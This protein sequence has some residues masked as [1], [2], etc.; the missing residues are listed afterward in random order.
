[1]TQKK[2]ASSKR[3]ARAAAAGRKTVHR[4]R[5][6]HKR[7]LLHPFSVMVLLCAGVLILGST[8]HGSADSYDVTASVN[9]PLP[10]APAVIITPLDQLHFSAQRITAE[11]TCPPASYV[12]LYR[13]GVFSGADVCSGNHFQILTYLSPGANSLEAKVY[14]VTNN[15]GPSSPPITLY[16]DVIENPPPP[17]SVPPVTLKIDRV[18]STGYRDGT[19]QTSVRPTLVGKAPP[20]SDVVVT[21]HSEVKT[22]LTQADGTGYWSC[23]L[24]EELPPGLHHV[25]VTATT[26]DGQ[27]LS[28]PSFQISALAALPDIIKQTL[29]P[30]LIQSEYSYQ[31]HHTGQTFTFSMGVGGGTAPFDVVVDWGDKQQTKLT[32]NDQNSF[33]V[34]HTYNESADY[35]IIVTMTDANGTSSSLQL[36]AVVRDT[37]TPAAVTKPDSG[38][39]ALLGDMKRFLWVIW[40]V[41]I[42]V[43]LMVVSYWIGEQ[44]AYNRL[45]SRR[46][47]ST[48]KGKR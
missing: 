26:L 4:R 11:G 8:F 7:I 24:A 32:R 39:A 27:E 14:N 21:F 48:G 25:D 20:Y 2:R 44:E 42:A 33:L 28:L 17:P 6:L 38:P 41:Y 10:P 13:N 31:A 9:A 45:W 46:A 43:M 19:L 47:H 1:M 36:L 16:Y 34:T 23:T 22:C 37:L 18:E 3:P 29:A 40:P 15:E 5:P 35:P 12:K 30:I